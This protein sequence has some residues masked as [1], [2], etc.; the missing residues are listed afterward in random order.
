[1]LGATRGYFHPMHC[2]AEDYLAAIQAV[3]R[4]GHHRAELIAQGGISHSLLQMGETTL[5]RDHTARA[6]DLARHLGARRFEA[7]NFM[8]LAEADR[9][10]GRRWEA[11][12]QLRDALEISRQTGFGFVGPAILGALALA[13]DDPMERRG[14]LD[15]G[16]RALCAGSVSHNHLWFYFY[17]MAA[18]LGVGDWAEAERY[19]AALETYTSA[20]PLARA[21]FVT[22]LAGFQRGADLCDP[23]NGSLT[24][25]AEAV[26]EPQ[27]FSRA[28]SRRRRAS[29]GIGDDGQLRPETG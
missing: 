11:A 4:V 5:A 18:A 21:D 16:E 15:E 13:T 27:R 10:E 20:E 2:A 25:R 29:D 6:R 8:R 24:L 22:L 14:A 26:E 9:L 23:I 19:A 1:M 12:A 7:Y 17:A 3:R 28:E